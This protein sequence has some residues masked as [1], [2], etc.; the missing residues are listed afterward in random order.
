M[1]TKA[2]PFYKARHVY[3][4]GVGLLTAAAAI[5]ASIISGIVVA[6]LGCIVYAFFRMI[7]DA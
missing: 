7:G 2:S 3:F 5:D 1:K 6:G 4:A